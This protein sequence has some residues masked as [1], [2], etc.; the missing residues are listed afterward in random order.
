MVWT[1]LIALAVV[2]VAFRV[3]FIRNNAVGVK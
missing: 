3:D 2:V 1:A